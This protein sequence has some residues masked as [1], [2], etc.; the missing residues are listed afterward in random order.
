MGDG[1]KKHLHKS[2]EQEQTEFRSKTLPH[3]IRIRIQFHLRTQVI[4]R[5]SFQVHTETCKYWWLK[6]GGADN[7]S[8]VTQ[9]F[10]M[11]EGLVLIG[12]AGLQGGIPPSCKKGTQ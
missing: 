4:N 2:R 1:K 12:L 5:L 7:F 8:A 6:K 10:V 9:R 3:M 11:P